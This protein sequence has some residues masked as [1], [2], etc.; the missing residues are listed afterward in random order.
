M[1]SEE[2]GHQEW[3]LMSSMDVRSAAHGVEMDWSGGRVAVARDYG[4]AA[5]MFVMRVEGGN[6][7]A[8]VKTASA[9]PTTGVSWS[10]D[11]RHVVV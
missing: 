7:D 9:K 8:R 4:T 11:G 10:G 1:Y 3:G 2:R 5:P 6:E